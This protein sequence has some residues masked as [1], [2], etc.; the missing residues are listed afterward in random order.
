MMGGR[1]KKPKWMSVTSHWAEQAGGGHGH[2]GG[3]RGLSVVET[4]T[5]RIYW[6]LSLINLL[7]IFRNDLNIPCVIMG[8]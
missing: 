2:G 8:K 4:E 5:S 7:Q 6:R 1:P 3:L